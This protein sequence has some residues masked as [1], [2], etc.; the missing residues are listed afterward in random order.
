MIDL[1]QVGDLWRVT[2]NRPDKANALT[3]A[4]EGQTDNTYAS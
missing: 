4:I 2:L 3:A 1:A